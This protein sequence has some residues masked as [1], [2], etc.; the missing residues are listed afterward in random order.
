MDTSPVH[1]GPSARAVTQVS[2]GQ[3]AHIDLHDARVARISIMPPGMA[4]IELGHICVYFRVGEDSFEV[5][6]ARAALQLEDVKS[7]EV[8]GEFRDDDYISEGAFLDERGSEI[9]E[10]GPEWLEQARQLDLLFAGSGFEAHFSMGRARFVL[11]RLLK[12]L[13]GWSGPLTSPA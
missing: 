2:T 4:R 13:E 12:K 5:W 8:R 3:I 10:L 11:E 1:T 6:S 7:I 9:G